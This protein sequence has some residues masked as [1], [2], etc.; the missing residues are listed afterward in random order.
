MRLDVGAK[1]MGMQ[2][3]GV[4]DIFLWTDKD[5]QTYKLNMVGVLDRA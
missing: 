5:M 3:L 2:L 1:V 4:D